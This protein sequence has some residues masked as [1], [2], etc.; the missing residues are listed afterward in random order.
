M[1]GGASY[2]FMHTSATAVAH[3]IPNAWYLTLEGQTHEVAAEVIAPVLVE[4]FNSDTARGSAR[5][6][7]DRPGGL[8]ERVRQR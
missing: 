5:A 8:S 7:A 6:A 1:D 2:P 3:A 4:L